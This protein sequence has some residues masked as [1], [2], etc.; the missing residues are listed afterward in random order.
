MSIKL[1]AETSTPAITLGIQMTQLNPNE[2]GVRIKKLR[3]EAGCTLAQWSEKLSISK[4]MI[5]RY[6]LGY[7]LPCAE[8][9]VRLWLHYGVDPIRL[10]TG[11]F[12][13]SDTS[14]KR[15]SRSLSLSED[16]KDLI[17]SIRSASPEIRLAIKSVVALSKS[18]VAA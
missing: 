15:G 6:E 14:K 17:R 12:G 8:F 2:V 11:D 9:S 16:E 18:Q 13:A 5:S 3:S 10:L 1:A 4:A 7:C